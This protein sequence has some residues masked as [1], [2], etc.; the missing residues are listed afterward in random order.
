MAKGKETTQR[1]FKGPKVTVSFD[2]GPGALPGGL[3][4]G[5]PDV[6]ASGQYLTRCEVGS[7]FAEYGSEVL[8][9]IK[10]N[11][12]GERGPRPLRER[13][14]QRATVCGPGPGARGG[15]DRRPRVAGDIPDRSFAGEITGTQALS[16]RQPPR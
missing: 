16:V 10:L 11:E 15:Q 14:P 1:P 9:E 4:H 13:G 3:V 2:S 7:K 5:P 8:A 12:P 6:V